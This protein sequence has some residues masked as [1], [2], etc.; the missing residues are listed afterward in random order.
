MITVFRDKYVPSWPKHLRCI[1]VER[2]FVVEA[3]HAFERTYSTDAH[4][5]PYRAPNGRRLSLDA[6][7]RGLTVELAHVVFDVDGPNHTAPP[8][9]RVSLRERIQTLSAEHPGL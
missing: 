2:G 8:E 4:F 3:G 9:W 6:L 1:D 7:D 5:A